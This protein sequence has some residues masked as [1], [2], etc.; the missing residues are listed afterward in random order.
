MLL[1]DFFIISFRSC[2]GRERGSGQRWYVGEVSLRGLFSFTHPMKRGCIQSWDDMDKCFEHSIFRLGGGGSTL[3]PEHLMMV[4]LPP[5][6]PDIHCD[7][8]AELLFETHHLPAVCFGNSAAMSIL[9]SGKTTGMV[10]ESGDGVTSAVPVYEGHA[11]SYASSRIPFGGHDVTN[12]FQRLLKELDY[13]F[14]TTAEREILEDIKVKLAYVSVGDEQNGTASYELP[15]GQVIKVGDARYRCTESL[16]DPSLAGSECLGL[17][18]LL[19]Q[20]IQRIP[21]TDLRHRMYN[22]IVLAGGTTAFAGFRERL[23][24]ELLPL[25]PAE[26]SMKISGRSDRQ[27]CAW[28]GASMFAAQADFASRCATK[29]EYLEYGAKI[30]RRK[31]F[32]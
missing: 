12:Y 18:E 27:Y 32:F 2:V 19:S 1:N 6:T 22:E 9:A 14:S 21:D 13:D 20:S 26:E 24:K 7:K 4:S 16:F 25:V 28:I 23:M 31:S 3:I 17:H 5:L 8:L 11:I 30:V 15:D 29:A 10:L